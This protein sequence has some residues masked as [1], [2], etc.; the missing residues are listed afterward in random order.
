MIVRDEKKIFSQIE[1]E[2]NYKRWRK[3]VAKEYARVLYTLVEMS[4]GVKW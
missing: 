3:Q 2:K 1:E 4:E